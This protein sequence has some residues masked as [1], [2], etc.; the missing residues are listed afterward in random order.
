MADKQDGDVAG[1]DEALDALLALILEEYV[2]DR[3]RLINDEDIGLGDRGDGEGDA[4]HHARGEVL[5]R[6]I[7]EVGE[8]GKVD[9]LLE[10]LVDEILGVTQQGAIEIDVLASGE[11]QVKTGSQLDQRG[12]IAADDAF[13]FAG[14]EHAGDDL[15]HGGLTRAVGPHQ[16]HDLA[17]VDGE[18]DVLECLELG[19]EQ[20]MA[21]QLD[22][23]LFKAV[24]LFG[25]HVED[26]GD[27]FDLYGR[28][29]AQSGSRFGHVGLLDVEDEL[30]LALAEDRI[31]DGEC[32]EGPGNTHKEGETAGHG[33]IQ[34]DVAH[35]RHIVVHG[36]CVHNHLNRLGHEGDHVGGP[37]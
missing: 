8:L 34:E 3:K 23:V 15:E 10:M 32:D 4:R 20:L 21:H 5:H 13:A 11:L 17:A 2:A 31:A 26:H 22:E 25:R 6:H 1:I 27:V 36:V 16:T 37:E 12:D 19:E 28:L 14:L 30:V 35:K 33:L 18:R 7:D 24:E 29:G 9:D